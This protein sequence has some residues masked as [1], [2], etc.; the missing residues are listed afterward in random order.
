MGASPDSGACT[1]IGI[2]MP[3]YGPQTINLQPDYSTTNDEQP[4]R[5]LRQLKRTSGIPYPRVVRQEWQGHRPG[6]GRYN[7]FLKVNASRL[8]ALSQSHHLRATKRSTALNC[9]HSIEAA[10][11]SLCR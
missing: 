3:R 9:A 1:P 8:I 10:T 11:W 6:S 7:D 2:R 5:N 4:G